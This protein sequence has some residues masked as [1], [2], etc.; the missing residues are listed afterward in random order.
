MHPGLLRFPGGSF[1]EG[2]KP[3]RRVAME[4]NAR[5]HGSAARHLEHLGLSVHQWV[6]AFTNTCSWP[7]D[8]GAEPLY[9]VHV[10]MAERGFVPLDQ[11]EPWIQDMLDAI[12]YANGPAGFQA[13]ARCAPGMG[14]RL[15]SI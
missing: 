13:G 2:A 9:V 4:G 1:S 3:N 5:R 7:E 12:E 15:L 8:L 10:G 6:R 14:I 11:L